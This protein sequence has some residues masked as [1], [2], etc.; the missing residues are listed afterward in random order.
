MSFLQQLVLVLLSDS[1]GI[2]YAVWKCQD[3]PLLGRPLADWIS[4]SLIIGNPND[5][6]Y[7]YSLRWKTDGVGRYQICPRTSHNYAVAV[8]PTVS[9]SPRNFTGPFVEIYF[10]QSTHRNYKRLGG[11]MHVQ[12]CIHHANSRFH[13]HTTDAY[14]FYNRL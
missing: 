7:Q 9:M 3:G 8:R 4:I 10:N 1:F 11:F 6:Y 2:W 12:L 5:L 14:G 13:L